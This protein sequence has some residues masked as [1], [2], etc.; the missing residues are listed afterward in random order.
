MQTFTCVYT[1]ICRNRHTLTE[2][3]SG[4]QQE[5]LKPDKCMQRVASTSSS[6]KTSGTSGNCNTNLHFIQMF[7]LA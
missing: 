5:K 3:C 7:Q 4:M 1:D 2:L 6:C